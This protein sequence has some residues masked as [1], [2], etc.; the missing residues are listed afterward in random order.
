MPDTDLFLQLAQKRSDSPP[1]KESIEP[2]K[3]QAAEAQ[4]TALER[5]SSGKAISQVLKTRKQGSKGRDET[6]HRD[7]RKV[8]QQEPSLSD[9][10]S[11]DSPVNRPVNQSIDRPADSQL[12]GE[13][14][15][16]P[17]AFYIPKV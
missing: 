13:V 14:V 10:Q 1:P 11:V 5:V 17:V 12:T 7:S 16:R 15:E 9:S 2:T 3:K 8:R 4:K 6:K